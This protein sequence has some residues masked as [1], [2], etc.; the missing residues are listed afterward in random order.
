MQ[1]FTSFRFLDRQTAKN[2]W[3]G[4]EAKTLLC[5]LPATSH[6]LNYVCLTSGALRDDQARMHA[7]HYRVRTLERFGGLCPCCTPHTPPSIPRAPPSRGL[8]L[9]QEVDC[10]GWCSGS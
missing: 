1:K 5:S 6:K 9:P 2:K 7:P 4:C 3:S 8:L 10:S